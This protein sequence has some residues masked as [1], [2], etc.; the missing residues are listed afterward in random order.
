MG[1]VC[2][3]QRALTHRDLSI[4]G[5]KPVWGPGKVGKHLRPPQKPTWKVQKVGQI[6]WSNIPKVGRMDTLV[7]VMVILVVVTVILYW[8]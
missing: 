1:G 8:C 3:T 7:V 6:W 5:V 4:G 2:N